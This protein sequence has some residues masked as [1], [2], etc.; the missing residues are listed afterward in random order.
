MRHSSTG[1]SDET[2]P[3]NFVMPKCHV[4][5]VSGSPLNGILPLEHAGVGPKWGSSV[6]DHL[7][8]Y[9]TLRHC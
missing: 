5:E 8:P 7:P 6:P 9:L 2:S 1:D 4:A 3:P